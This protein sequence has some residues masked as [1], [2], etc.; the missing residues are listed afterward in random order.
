MQKSLEHFCGHSFHSV[1]GPPRCEVVRRCRRAWNT[2]AG[3]AFT[4]FKAHQDARS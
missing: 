4:V 3:T 1:Q 2:S